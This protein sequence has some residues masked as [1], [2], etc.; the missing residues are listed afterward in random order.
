MQPF[1]KSALITM[2]VLAVALPA[3]GAEYKF[4]LINKSALAIA[5]MYVG[6]SSSEDWGD[7]ILEKI[8]EIVPGGE[9]TITVVTAGEECL[10]DFRFETPDGVELEQYEQNVCSLS[11]FTLR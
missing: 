9:A 4:V 5:H 8:G 10:Y 6:P 11:D 3:Q 2:A 7:D 1:L